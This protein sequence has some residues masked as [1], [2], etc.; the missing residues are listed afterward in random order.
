MPLKRG[1][2]VSLTGT[3]ILVT[4]KG[5]KASYKTFAG[6][7]IKSSH[8]DDGAPIYKI[9]HYS[10]TWNAETKWKKKNIDLQLLIETY[11]SL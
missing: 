5:A 8:N 7:V 3:V 11:L 1:H 2:V 4:G 6:V 9:G 10:D